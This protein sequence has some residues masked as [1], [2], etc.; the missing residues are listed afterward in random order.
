MR[1][2]TEMASATGELAQTLYDLTTSDLGESLSHLLN[3]L[4]GVEIRAPEFLR[5][6]A[7]QDVDTLMS[8]GEWIIHPCYCP[9]W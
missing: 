5:I 6:K 1:V 3:G 4:A 9:G 2:R 7:E 8:T